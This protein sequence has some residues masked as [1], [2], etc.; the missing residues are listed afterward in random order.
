MGGFG[1][2]QVHATELPS[3]LS[4]AGSSSS[5]GDG[6]QD[7]PTRQAIVVAEQVLCAHALAHLH[8]RLSHLHQGILPWYHQAPIA[9]PG[10]IQP[11]SDRKGREYKSLSSSDTL[12]L[13]PGIRVFS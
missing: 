6:G 1:L 13:R 3:G 4:P 8:A 12:V 5:G 9:R 2:P 11:F 7:R 10:I